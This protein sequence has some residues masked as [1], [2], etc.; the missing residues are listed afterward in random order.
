MLY[1][2]EELTEL[3][4]TIFTIVDI[5]AGTAELH[6]VARYRGRLNK[7]SLEAYNWLSEAIRPFQ[8]T[9]LFREES[10][11]QVIILVSSR[12]EPK[13]SNPWINLALFIL[14]LLS[15]FYAGMMYVTGNVFPSNL[16]DFWNALL[17]GGLPF[18]LSMV[19]IFGT[20]EFGHYFAGRLHGV[21]VTLPYFIPLPFSPLGTMG[22]FINMKEQPRNRRDLLDIGIAGP[23]AGFLV[24]LVVLFVGL[25]LSHLGQIETQLPS[26]MAL[27]VEGSSVL[28]LLMKF[29][30]F[31]KMLPAPAHYTLPPLLHWVRYFF[32]GTPLPLGATDVMLSPVAWAGWAGLLITSLNLIPAGQLDGGHLFYVLF[33]KDKARKL[34][35]FILVTLV[36][37]GFLYSGWWLWAVII[38]LLGR[39]YA[40]PL[41]QITKLDKKRQRLAILG[42]V[43][44]ILTFTPIPLAIVQ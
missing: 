39:T 2:I 13:P 10:G 7:D 30:A 37:L 29:L 25:K 6:F 44:L 11:Q 31:G 8:L 26:G 40:E 16:S 32:T 4:G 27:E 20:H 21:K 41:D 42:I 22:A 14:T 5:T 12:P 28:Y 33:G 18:G 19:A 43:I 15:V 23:L 1:T 24:S 3:V 17:V 34:I 38:L 35:P 36:L 9:P